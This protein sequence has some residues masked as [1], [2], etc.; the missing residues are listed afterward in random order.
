V[1]GWNLS[2]P[3]NTGAVI[4]TS[5]A[6]GAAGFV[7]VGDTDPWHPKAV[8]TSMGSL[9]ALPVRTVEHDS[10]WLRACRTHGVEIFATDCREGEPLPGARP[11]G[12]RLALVLGSEAFG[13]PEDVLARVDRR[14][15]IPM[16]A[17]VDSYS[18]NAAAA[19]LAYTLGRKD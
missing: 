4:R 3:G 18:V 12:G 2:D 5:L 8:R 15:T 1:V 19:I 7:A 16:P 13:L 10:E 14:V 17:G 11:R 6:A 9:F